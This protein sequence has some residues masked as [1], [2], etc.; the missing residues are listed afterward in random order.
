MNNIKVRQALSKAVDSGEIINTVGYGYGTKI[1]TGLIPGLKTYFNASLT[2]YYKKD[3]AAAKKLLAEAGYPNGFSLT[4]TVP[5]NYQFHVNTAQVIVNELKTIGVK[6][7]IRQVDWSTWLSRVYLNRQY[8]ATIIGLDGT[9]LSPRSFLQRYVTGDS[10]NF[11]HF[12]SSA[13]DTLY[14]KAITETNAE[15]RVADYKQL[16]SILTKEAASVYIQD[17]ASLTA[18]KKGLGGYLFYPLYVQDMSTVYY[19]K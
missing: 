10:G 8:E 12:S 7:N 14:A 5:S 16:Q 17:P 18:V 6:A 4:I 15:K 13:Y 11:I 9:T 19:T 3:A 1:G 2:G